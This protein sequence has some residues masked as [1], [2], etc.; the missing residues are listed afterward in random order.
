MPISFFTLFF[1]SGTYKIGIGDTSEVD[2]G[3]KG[4]TWGKAGSLVEEV[5]LDRYVEEGLDIVM[6]REPR[7][8]D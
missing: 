3:V 2:R 4:Y 6:S 8:A 5:I 7:L 1:C